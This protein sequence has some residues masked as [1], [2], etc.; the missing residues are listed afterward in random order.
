MKPSS[1]RHTTMGAICEENRERRRRD[2]VN[3]RDCEVMSGPVRERA[4][5]RD[6][7]CHQCLQRGNGLI[8][9]PLDSIIVVC[10][11]IEGKRGEATELTA[12]PN[13]YFEL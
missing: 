5:D 2:E 10:C 12:K 6:E 8:G 9:N 11:C 3:D 4:V 7:L 13:F 1:S